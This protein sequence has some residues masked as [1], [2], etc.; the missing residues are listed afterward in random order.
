MRGFGT[1]LHPHD[2]GHSHHFKKPL[3]SLFT[4]SLWLLF[5]H[6]F[7]TVW[8]FFECHVNRI[9]SYS[10]LCLPLPLNIMLPYPHWSRAHSGYRCEGSHCTGPPPLASPSPHWWA[11]VLFPVWEIHTCIFPLTQVFMSLGKTRRSRIAGSSSMTD[12]LKTAKP[13]FQAAAPA[14]IP[15]DGVRQFLHILANACVYALVPVCNFHLHFPDDCSC[16]H[17]LM[18]H[19]YIFFDEIS[20][21]LFCPVLNWVI[22]LFNCRAI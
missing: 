11:F 1:T 22:Y 4:P 6:L 16:S 14:C 10:L 3:V 9:I 19:S 17:M 7:S 5:F 21:Q 8:P 15:T 13:S 20:A 2:R 18:H 12:F